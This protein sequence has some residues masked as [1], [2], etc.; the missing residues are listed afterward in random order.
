ME[1][2]DLGQIKQLVKEGYESKLFDNVPRL[3]YDLIMWK[4]GK[5]AH[6]VVH[7][8]FPYQDGSSDL[9]AFM[10]LPEIREIQSKM[11]EL[12]GRLMQMMLAHLTQE[13]KA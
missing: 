6:Q 8:D 4:P 1:K 5:D 11:R 2:G 3:R 7:F 13:V 9:A 10:G 12:Q